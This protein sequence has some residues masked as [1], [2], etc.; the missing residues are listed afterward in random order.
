[1]GLIYWFG[2]RRQLDRFLTTL[3][4]GTCAAY[5]LLPYFP[6]VAPRVAFPGQDLPHYSGLWR[7][8][9]VFLL[10]H[11]DIS[12]SVFPSGHVAVAFSSAFGVLRVLP[13]QRTI[14]LMLFA[15]A[16]AVFAATIY[17]RYHY[18]ADGV[19]GIGIAL[20]AWLASEALER[21]A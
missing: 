9:N 15:A 1:M 14:L 19:A 5:A 10:D 3:F 6:S 2:E 13:K 21:N 12:T 17:C 20:L 11:A 18:A 7:S 4:L 16:F 8:V